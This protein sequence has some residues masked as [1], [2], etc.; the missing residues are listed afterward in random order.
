MEA[1]SDTGSRKSRQR[2]PLDTHDNDYGAGVGYIKRCLG[3]YAN[4]DN[5]TPTTTIT[6]EASVATA[7]SGTVKIILA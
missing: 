7:M 3:R 5:K 4:K 6:T 2:Q 1:A